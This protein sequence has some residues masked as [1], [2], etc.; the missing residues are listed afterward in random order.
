MKTLIIIYLFFLNWV[1]WGGPYPYFPQN[2][3]NATTLNYLYNRNSDST[4]EQKKRIEEMRVKESAEM[5]A[6]DEYRKKHGRPI[7]EYILTLL[8]Y[9][10]LPGIFIAHCIFDYFYS[11]DAHEAR[12]K[13]RGHDE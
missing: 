1:L 9:V 8:F 2:Y 12:H 5:E 3:P 10:G 13:R 6:R 7:G 4:P 11:W